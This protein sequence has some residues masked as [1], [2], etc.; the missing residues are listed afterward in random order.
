MTD[1]E[2]PSRPGFPGPPGKLV[3]TLP[4]SSLSYA[5]VLLNQDTL[6]IKV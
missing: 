6:A 3:Q 4:M 2:D 1:G 5:S